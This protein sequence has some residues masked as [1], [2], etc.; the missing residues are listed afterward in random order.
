MT[1]PA[2]HVLADNPYNAVVHL[3]SDPEATRTGPLSG[4]PVVVKDLIDVA[5]VPTRCGSAV[6]AE[7]PPAREDAAVV[8]LLR[9]AGAAVLAKSHTHEFGYGPTGDVAAGGPCRNPHDPQRITGGS[10]SGS[11]AL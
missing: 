9:A 7:A 6:L 1:D 11:A 10:S 2:G 3:V 5:G 4:V 8:A